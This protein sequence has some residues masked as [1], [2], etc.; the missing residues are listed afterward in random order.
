[1]PLLAAIVCYL[2]KWEPGVELTRV[3]FVS[4]ECET[5]SSGEKAVRMHAVHARCAIVPVS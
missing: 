3:P 5:M 1:M 4:P 2:V